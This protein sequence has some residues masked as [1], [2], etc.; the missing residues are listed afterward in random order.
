[1]GGIENSKIETVIELAN[2]LSVLLDNLI[3]R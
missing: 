3:G 2:A 1:M